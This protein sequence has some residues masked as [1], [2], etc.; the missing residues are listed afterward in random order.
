VQLLGRLRPGRQVAE[1]KMQEREE[2]AV[3][4]ELAPPEHV[5]ALCDYV[6]VPRE[7]ESQPLDRQC[8][9]RSHVDV[10]VGVGHEPGRDAVLDEAPDEVVRV[11]NWNRPF[12][13]NDSPDTACT[14]RVSAV[15]P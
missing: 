9:R 15:R 13:I 10:D 3:L 8:R 6:R 12:L 2:H 11:S 4:L 7:R 14:H 1:H 5:L